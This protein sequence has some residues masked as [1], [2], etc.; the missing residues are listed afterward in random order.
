MMVTLSHSISLSHDCEILHFVTNPL[1]CAP[2]HRAFNTRI[3]AQNE[4]LRKQFSF[5]FLKHLSSGKKEM[6]VYT[7]QSSEKN[8]S[9][10]VSNGF[11]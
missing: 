9:E 3:K 11:S 8:G 1:E 6:P 2:W 10:H 4:K 7:K 5:Q